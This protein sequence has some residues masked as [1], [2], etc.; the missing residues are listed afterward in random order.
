M[1]H[2]PHPRILERA[3]KN[4]SLHQNTFNERLA[5][6]IT[7]KFGTMWAFYALLIWMIAWPLLAILGVSVFQFDPYPFIFLLFLSNIVQL[8]A[9]PVLAVGQQI[10]NRT[11]EHQINQT[12]KDAEAILHM[13]DEIHRLIKVNNR[14]TEEIHRMSVKKGHIVDD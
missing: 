8:L 1:D 6:F 2:T 14:L 12:Y 10:L 9:L 13:E 11:I 4:Q 3:K 7:K 5:L